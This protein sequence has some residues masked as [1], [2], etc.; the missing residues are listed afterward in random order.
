MHNILGEQEDFGEVS[1]RSTALMGGILMILINLHTTDPYF[2]LAAEEYVFDSMDDKQ[3]FFMLWQN[4]NAIIIGK[5]QNTIEEVNEEF[6]NANDIKVVRRLSGGGAVYHDLGNINFTFI[7]KNNN[8]CEMDFSKYMSLMTKS[9]NKMG[10]NA[11]CNTR[12]DIIIDGK[13]VSGNAQYMKKD[14][15]LH[16]GTLLYKSDLDLL[17]KSLNVKPFKIESKGVKSVK[18]RVANISDYMA[19][20]A[21]TNDFKIE[22]LKNIFD[23]NLFEEYCFT[24]EDIVNINKIS[25]EKYSTWKWNYGYSPDYNLRREKKFD[26]G[27]ITSYI[28]VEHGRIINIKFYGD[29]FGIGDINE[30]EN[31]LSKRTMNKNV[32]QTALEDINVEYYIY[33]L[34]KKSFMELF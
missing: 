14:K 4:H 30:L 16:H 17:E 18:G 29:F 2:N 3:D 5:Y 32:I 9:L 26:F 8:L 25:S 33:G 6:V 27:Y 23:E 22:L 7:N 1:L 34:D 20:P 28:Q 24:D 21:D 19:D 15:I 11:E 12:N 13:K 10:L 31:F